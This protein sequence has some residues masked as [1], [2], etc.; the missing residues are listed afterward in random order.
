MRK[1]FTSVLC[2]VVFIGCTMPA[3]NP[4]NSAES[5]TNTGASMPNIDTSLYSTDQ[6]S[7]GRLTDTLS[8]GDTMPRK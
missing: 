6:M 1:V 8:A 2:V 7:T 4:T 3:D 5:P